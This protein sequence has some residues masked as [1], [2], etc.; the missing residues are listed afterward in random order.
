[1]RVAVRFSCQ[2]FSALFYAHAGGLAKK[3]GFVEFVG[4]TDRTK[5]EGGGLPGVM[6]GLN[7]ALPGRQNAVLESTFNVD[8]GRFSGGFRYAAIIMREGSVLPDRLAMRA[9]R[10][11]GGANRLVAHVYGGPWLF[12]THKR[13]LRFSEVRKTHF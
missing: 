10:N 13:G 6:F 3:S 4:G 8:L 9:V 7:F 5:A 12:M 2:T 11:Q 1:M